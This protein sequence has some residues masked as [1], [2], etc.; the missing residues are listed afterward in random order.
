[1]LNI[2]HIPVAADYF[3][4]L[5]RQ[6]KEKSGD[7]K[8]QNLNEAIRAVVSCV[9]T[10][11]G[12]RQQLACYEANLTRQQ[13]KYNAHFFDKKNPAKQHQFWSDL[14]TGKD[15]FS[16]AFRSTLETFGAR[17]TDKVDR[18][19]ASHDALLEDVSLHFLSIV[20]PKARAEKSD[21][22]KMLAAL[23][24]AIVTVCNNAGDATPDQRARLRAALFAAQA[25]AS[26]THALASA[27]A[28]AS[29]PVAA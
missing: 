4:S 8:A 5:S 27:P 13:E 11:N 9:Y 18:T 12:H 6:F 24:R 7:A 21:H 19:Q 29:E 1:M 15:K 16:I 22:E 2:K 26:A 17:I 3:N 23:E 10:D 28:H 25:P 14:H 20:A